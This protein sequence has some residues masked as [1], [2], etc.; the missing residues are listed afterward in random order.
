[1]SKES[2]S[3]IGLIDVQF[4]EVSLIAV[5]VVVDYLLRSQ[6]LVNLP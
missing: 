4:L 2:E 1:M 5:E 6:L 3:L